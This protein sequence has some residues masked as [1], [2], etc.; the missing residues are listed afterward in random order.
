MHGRSEQNIL[1]RTIHARG[2][3][4]PKSHIAYS[5]SFRKIHKCPPYFRKA[6]TCHPYF[7]KVYVL[8]LNSRF[9]ASPY[10]DAFMRHA[11]SCTRTERPWSTLPRLYLR[12]SDTHYHLSMFLFFEKRNFVQAAT[13]GRREGIKIP[14]VDV[15]EVVQLC[16]RNSRTR[17]RKRYIMICGR[18][19]KISVQT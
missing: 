5:P 14:W 11:Q 2:F 13:R 1:I 16:Y 10:F 9:F 12:N 15:K 4:P 6:H 3:H 7:R 17:L 19:Q 18:R 8:L